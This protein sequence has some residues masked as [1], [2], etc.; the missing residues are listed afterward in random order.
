MKIS[1][2]VGR[3]SDLKVEMKRRMSLLAA[4]RT[5]LELPCLGS[6]YSLGWDWLPIDCWPGNLASLRVDS[7]VCC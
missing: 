7:L 1:I 5:D 2:E 6:V 4:Q 3:T